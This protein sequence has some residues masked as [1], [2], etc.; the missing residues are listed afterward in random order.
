METIGDLV[1]HNA[2]LLRQAADLVSSLTQDVYVDD[3]AAF[4]QSSAGMHFRHLLDFYQRFLVTYRDALDYDSR[5]RDRR[6]EREPRHAVSRAREIVDALESLAE[7][8]QH[9]TRIRWAGRRSL[10]SS[11]GRE[12]QYLADHTIHH[13]AIM[14]MILVAL[15]IDVSP[16]FGVAPSTLEYRK[17]Q[18]GE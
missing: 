14:A 6:T 16:E 17:S 15:G 12:L 9:D 18:G 8:E 10:V 11:V 3:Q 7:R 13:Y 1:Q 2:E 4:T 5:D